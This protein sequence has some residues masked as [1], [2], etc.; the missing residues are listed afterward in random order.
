MKKL[1]SDT[2]IDTLMPILPSHLQV[3]KVE[4]LGVLQVVQQ[5][6]WRGHHNVDAPFQLLGFRA[7]AERGRAVT[8]MLEE[9]FR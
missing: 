6:A 9:Q 5:P 7:P 1:W 2:A 8:R 3:R 4:A